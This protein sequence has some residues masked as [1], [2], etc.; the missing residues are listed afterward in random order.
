MI[1]AAIELAPTA[2]TRA[3]CLALGLPRATFY[4]QRSPDR[5]L[6][7]SRPRPPLALSELERRAV[8]A[9]LHSERFVDA[10]PRQIYATLLDEERYGYAIAQEV[11]RLSGGRVCVEAGNLHRH[12]QKLVRQGLVTPSERRPAPEAEDERRR[13]YAHGQKCR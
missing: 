10:A 8:L 6:P 13:Y 9:V 5:S 2:G 4:R 1:A 7:T 3:A 11:L 12:I